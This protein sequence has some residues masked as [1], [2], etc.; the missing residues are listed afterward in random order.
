MI[1]VNRNHLVLFHLQ[2]I[3]RIN[4]YNKQTKPR[5]A[6]QRELIHAIPGLLKNRLHISNH[7]FSGRYYNYIFT[8]ALSPANIL[9]D[10]FTRADDIKGITFV[11][12]RSGRPQEA[13][14]ALRVSTRAAPYTLKNEAG[15]LASQSRLSP[16]NTQDRRHSGRKVRTRYFCDTP[17]LSHKFCILRFCAS[18]YG[19]RNCFVSSAS[20][21]MLC[22]QGN[23]ASFL[24]H[25][26]A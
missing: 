21:K 5:S 18:H 15:F 16:N 25:R 3:K 7:T 26:R 11:G 6:H 22:F 1:P 19:E 13:A 8:R 14:H 20:K 12:G 10:P 24:R 2:K 4:A 9:S 23:L 17:L